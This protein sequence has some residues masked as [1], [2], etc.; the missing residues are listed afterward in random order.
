MYEMIL[1]RWIATNFVKTS[2]NHD[3]KSCLNF[4][5]KITHVDYMMIHNLVKYLVQTRFCL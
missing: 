5:K 1:P 3:K 4:P 2:A